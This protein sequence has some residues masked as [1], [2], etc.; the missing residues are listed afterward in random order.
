MAPT[1]YA[2][3]LDGAFVVKKLEQASATH[4]FPTVADIVDFCA[5]LKTDPTLQNK[6]LLR[7]YYYD[8][9]PPKHSITNPISG[10]RFNLAANPRFQQNS[11]L[12][13]AL[14][15]MDD[16]A[17]RLGKVNGKGFKIGKAAM[18]E[19]MRRNRPLVANDLV[20]NIN[21]KGVDLRIGLDISK[22][23][24][25]RLVETIIVTTGDS[26]LVPAFKFAR[27]AGIRLYIHTMGHGVLPELKIHS[28]KVLG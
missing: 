8:A 18:Q 10:T 26:D 6:E 4:A 13:T 7:I 3:L 11:K 21:Q 16:F 25:E 24:L 14:E 23:A 28:D 2:I 15:L 27:R 19:L 20:P 1:R 17:V 22:L 9:L 5:T 12:L